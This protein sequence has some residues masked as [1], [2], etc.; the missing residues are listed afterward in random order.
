MKFFKYSPKNDQGFTLVEVLISASIIALLF[1]AVLNLADLTLSVTN[2]NKNYVTA[3]ALANE[4]MEFIKNLTY[5]KVDIA[6]S[7]SLGIINQNEK[8]GIFNVYTNIATI[9]DAY[10]GTATDT[11]PNDYKLATVKVSWPTKNTIK[12]VEV[13]ARIIPLNEEVADGT[14]L[15]ILKVTDSNFNPI[16]NA[17]VTIKGSSTPTNLVKYTDTDGVVLQPLSPAIDEY[18]VSVTKKDTLGNKIYS[19]DETIATTSFVA[20]KKPYSIF[21]AKETE[22]SFVIDKLSNLK[23]KTLNYNLLKNFKVSATSTGN[24]VSNISFA[25]DDFNGG[26]YLNN[27]YFTWLDSTSSISQIYVDKF[28]SN[29]VKVIDHEWANPVQIST[30]SF[31]AN[32]DIAT[33][34]SGDSYVV[35]D[36]SSIALGNL[37]KNNSTSQLA[38]YE[39]D[40]SLDFLKT[41]EENNQTHLS[42]FKNLILRVK[43]ISASIKFFAQ[44]STERFLSLFNNHT[45]DTALATGPAVQF[46]G[47]AEGVGAFTNNIDINVPV[48]LKNSILSNDLIIAYIES[49]KANAT[50]N[51]PFGWQR[52]TD[53]NTMRPGTDLGCT[54]NRDSSGAIFYKQA[55]TAQSHYVFSS[56]NSS[57]KVGIIRIYRNVDIAYVTTS[58]LRWTYS[59]KTI[60]G[61]LRPSPSNFVNGA[62]CLNVMGWGANT[63]SLVNHQDWW[64]FYDLVFPTFSTNRSKIVNT[65]SSMVTADWPNLSGTGDTAP[66]VINPKQNIDQ[67]SIG[68][69][70]MLKPIDLD[71]YI[72]VAGY[73]NT[74]SSAII[75]STNNDLGGKIIITR[76][77]PGTTLI[78]NIKLT[79]YGSVDAKTSLSNVRAYYKIDTTGSTSPKNCDDV[80][81]TGLST[82][83]GSPQNFDSENGS[84]TFTQDVSIS[85]PNAL[86]LFIISDINSNATSGNDIILKIKNPSTDIQT[87]SGSVKPAFSTNASSTIL[88]YDTRLNQIHYRFR[89]DDDSEASSTWAT[90]QDSK[91]ITKLDAPLRLRFEINNSGGVTSDAV[92][93]QLEY[94]KKGATC[95]GITASSWKKVLTNNSED[96]KINFSGHI[97]DGASSTNIM[98]GLSDENTNFIDGFVSNLSNPLS[99]KI[100]LSPLNFTEIEFA[101]SS[102][103]NTKDETNYCFR[104]TNFGDTSK[105]VYSNY[106][107]ITVS[108]DRNIF[109][110]S[111]NKD[112]ETRWQ[113]KKVNSSDTSE[114]TNPKIALTYNDNHPTSTIAWVDHRNGNADIYAQSF[115]PDALKIWPTDVQITS[116]STDENS[117]EIKYDK[118]DDNFV[119]AWVNEALT[120]KTLFLQK[121]S[122]NASSVWSMPIE[123]NATSGEKY[124]PSL[125]IDNNDNIYVAWET[126][127]SGKSK[128]RLA[129]LDATG[130]L[131]WLIQ[132]SSEDG[133]NQLLQ[134]SIFTDDSNVYISWVDDRNNNYD[135]YAQKISSLGTKLWLTDQ[136]LNTELNISDQLHPK[137]LI[138]NDGTL[139]AAWEDS[140]IAPKTHAYAARFN[141]PI[142]FTPM[143][144][145]SIKI[146]GAK[147]IG[148]G[149]LKYNLT[150]FITDSNGDLSIPIEW[151]SVGYT[152][153]SSSTIMMID[154]YLPMNIAPNENKLI[155]IFIKP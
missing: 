112:G 146:S 121:F 72:N 107:E 70:L 21:A 16:E 90:T 140:R 55:E 86:C 18:S 14:G 152:I 77:Y 49:S 36:D 45:T 109:I 34:P 74:L 22:D 2:N 71:N 85:Y 127:I 153:F 141:D 5:D 118:T 3:I 61:Y 133:S 142:A 89:Y 4:K 130:T 150:P 26:G 8:I 108:G 117:V 67:C 17:E 132:P 63:A 60:A 106:P 129:K 83:F 113:I 82:P 110:K 148:E 123:I 20:Y 43:S 143:G 27:T 41:Q 105:F 25:S 52:L 69:S 154:P 99:K 42:Y 131:L 100:T 80:N 39:P 58:T 88:I 137:L 32:P 11:V 114:Q 136:R 30:S 40:H 1:V 151:D 64:S 23:I 44:K 79:E 126:I 33:T 15:L 116:S 144:N 84:L 56:T 73:A 95:S 9:N 50:I 54:S 37:A 51:T 48:A 101:I 38:K 128:I 68:W 122:L 53:S 98:N 103:T 119:L 134:P 87:S 59:P 155:N 115:G 46:I 19:T 6:S 94:A 66:Q 29:D 96:W 78:K 104:L 93:Y 81:Y 57:Y 120:G 149:V 76:D 31:Q 145:V 28:N 92:N 124:S 111:L 35:W 102:T 65:K 10:D 138:N 97:V 47:M 7:T 147:E 75:P 139:F 13:N 91:L 12:E 62:G 135:I 24:Q 125:T